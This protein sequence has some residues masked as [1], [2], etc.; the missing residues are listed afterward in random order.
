MAM[1]YDP[2]ERGPSP[3]GVRS[4]ELVDRAR[5]DRALP[6]EVW[7]PAAPR[8]RGLDLEPREQ[9]AFRA[10]P[11]T[12]LSRQA[13]LRDAPAGGGRHPLVLYSHSSYG[14]RRQATFL[15]THL[16]SRGYVVGAVDHTGNTV[17]EW[18][19]RAPGATPVPAEAREARVQR[20]IA[21]RVPDLRFLMDTF[22]GLQG[23]LGGTVRDPA[24][25][26]DGDRAALCGWSF[27]GWAAL[28]TPEVDDRF[29]AVVGLAPGGSSNPLPGIL[30]LRLTFTWKRDVA[31]LLLAARDDQATPLEG[32]GDIFHRAP[33]PKQMLV[34]NDAG[35]G[36]FGDVIQDPG[37][38][39]AQAHL[40]TRGLTLAH[41]D[42]ALK[43][44]HAARDFLEHDPAGALRARGVDATAFP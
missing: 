40:F 36:H 2:F 1:T 44:E 19:E 26:I 38:S 21:D 7:Y 39:P 43:R 31:T 41:L 8:L 10:L 28:A 25:H 20:L 3:V 32:I 14:H 37:C 16:A 12:P 4:G 9:D 29:R 15:C 5:G 33:G 6:F 34:L 24:G 42:A 27:G 23:F 17:R 11:G 18:V 13:A 22:L 35:H 30:P